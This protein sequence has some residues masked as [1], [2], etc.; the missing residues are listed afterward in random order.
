MH[1]SHYCQKITSK[2][3]T[4]SEAVAYHFGQWEHQV[5]SDNQIAKQ[6]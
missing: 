3:I 5:P 4:L 2:N 6:R 1:F